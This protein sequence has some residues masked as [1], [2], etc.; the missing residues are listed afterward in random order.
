M[1]YQVPVGL[2]ASSPIDARQ[3]RPVIGKGSKDKQWSNRWALLAL[4][5]CHM[6]NKL[7]IHYMCAGSLGPSHAWSL[8]G[9]SLP[10]GPYV[11]RLVDPVGSTNLKKT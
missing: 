3:D 10:V 4:L 6:K 5:G 2:G 1:S 7:H 11:A 8:V 9:V